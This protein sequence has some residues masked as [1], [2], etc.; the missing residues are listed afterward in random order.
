MLSVFFVVP[1]SL[2]GFPR[3]EN[4]CCCLSTHH[5]LSDNTIVSS[6]DLIQFCPWCGERIELLEQEP[7]L[8]D[9]GFPE[10]F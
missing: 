9:A 7:A 4:L 5:L 8:A 1:R 10:D 6:L 3:P 2:R